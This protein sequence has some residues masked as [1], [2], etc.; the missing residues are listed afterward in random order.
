M[1]YLS[2]QWWLFHEKNL[3]Q[4]SKCKQHHEALAAYNKALDLAKRRGDS[5]AT[6][7]DMQVT[8]VSIALDRLHP[9]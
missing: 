3:M 7:D 2:R 1:Q 4:C 6:L 8:L 9:T 5:I